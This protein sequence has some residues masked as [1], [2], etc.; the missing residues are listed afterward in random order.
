MRTLQTRVACVSSG[1]LEYTRR[2]RTHK[3]GNPPI[4]ALV[5]SYLQLRGHDSGIDTTVI[6]EIAEYFEKELGVNIPP[7]QPLV[8]KDFNMTRAGIHADGLL[9]NEEIYNVFD[10]ARLLNRP[11]SVAITDKS[12][13]EVLRVMLDQRLKNETRETP[14]AIVARLNL[15][16][17][18]GDTGAITTSIGE[19]I[20]ENPKALEDYLAGKTGALNFLVGQ[21]M[22]KTRGKADP[23]ELN[24]MLA[25][26]LKKREA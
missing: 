5:L 23:A 14:A 8:G 4:E 10:T 19:A 6:T 25:E 7:N 18:S 3:A 20:N 21:V 22:K 11:V 26:A 9:K 16:K 17:T 13:V 12:G 1:G 24:R 2:L 15:A